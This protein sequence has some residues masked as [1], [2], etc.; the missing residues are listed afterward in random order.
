MLEQPIQKQ[1]EAFKQQILN[2]SL[3]AIN[4]KKLSLQKWKATI[5]SI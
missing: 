4:V 1:H 5:H 2:K 3:A